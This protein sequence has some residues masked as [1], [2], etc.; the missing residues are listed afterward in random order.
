MHL[1]AGVIR[2]LAVEVMESLQGF[3][4]SEL[5]A[6]GYAVSLRVHEYRRRGLENGKPY[7]A[8]ELP[9]FRKNRLPLDISSGALARYNPDIPV[10]V[11][12][13]ICNLHYVE[14]PLYHALHGNPAEAYGLLKATATD[15][16]EFPNFAHTKGHCGLL[17]VRIALRHKLGEIH[18]EPQ[19]LQRLLKISERYLLEAKAQTQK[20]GIGPTLLIE[21][22]L[23]IKLPE[24]K[25][26]LETDLPINPA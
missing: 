5:S 26:S 9:N 21:N 18:T 15:P 14:Q 19:D 22:C 2:S 25:A 20:E 23:H 4:Y 6:F 16:H 11:E 3:S 13:A 8:R 10:C 17:A 7:F 1:G 12:E 24:T